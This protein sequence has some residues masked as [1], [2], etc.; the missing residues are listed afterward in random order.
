M[1]GIPETHR[2]AFWVLALLI[3]TQAS[4]DFGFSLNEGSVA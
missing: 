2:D 1:S 3:G 4:R